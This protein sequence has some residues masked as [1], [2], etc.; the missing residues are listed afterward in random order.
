MPDKKQF[1]ESITNGYTFKGD[2]IKIGAGM[3]DGQVV[4]EAEVRI[5]LSTLNRHGLISG[6]TGGGKT[7]SFQMITELLSDAGIPVLLMD[8]KGDMSGIAA[9][10]V[11]N[12]KINSRYQSLKMEYKPETFPVELLTLSQQK[13]VRL[14]ATVSEFG[15]VLISKI[16]G[17]NDTQGGVVAM[18]FKY[19]DDN[20]MPVLDL[21]DFI[22]VL[23]YVSTDGKEELKVNY[24]NI[25]PATTGTIMRKVIELQQQGADI[26]FGEKSFEVEDLMRTTRDSRGMISILRVTDIQ[27]KPKLFSTFMLQMLAELYAV[28]PEVGDL[29]KPKLILFIDE[30]HLIFQE[31]TKALLNQIET[32]IK[33]IRS[34]GVGIYFCTQN[35]MDVPASVLGQLGLK[36]QHSLRAFTAKDRSVIKQTAENYPLTDFYKTEDLITQLGIGEAL[37]TLLNEKGIPT[38]LVHTMMCTPRSRMDILSATE[39]DA[40]VSNSTLVTKYNRE[41]DERSAYE[42]LTEKMEN[43]A[44]LTTL[45]NA[46]KTE[47][48]KPVKEQPSVIEQ[49]GSSVMKS[50][51]RQ[52]SYKIART[53][54][55]TLGLGGSNKGLRGLF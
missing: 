13:G 34:K 48:K 49:L 18:I 25:S 32:V 38:P 9:A 43:A 2:T 50:V 51:M 5:P 31:A 17:L 6:A 33:L 35:P 54:L 36:I 41:I 53:L 19:C 40:I 23:Q 1:T 42:M 11:A 22:K 52:S 16:L 29:P 37:V 28:L 20:G 14:R 7:K 44:K 12:D 30:A 45:Q 8:I 4:P 27:D 21:K 55:G 47:T 10:G 3:Y 39:I 26:F 15:P 24:G 46:Q